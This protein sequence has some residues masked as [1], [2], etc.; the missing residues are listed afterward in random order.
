MDWQTA[1]AFLTATTILLL[2]PGPVMAILVGNTMGSGRVAGLRTVLGIGLGEV[3]LIGALALSVVFSSR[4]LAEVFPYLSLA[5]AAYLLYLAATTLF[6]KGAGATS[7]HKAI[8]RSRGP[9]LDGL[10]I[11]L[12]NPTALIFYTAFFMPFLGRSGAAAG[13]LWVLAGLYLVTSL[14]FDTLCVVFAAQL[15][16]S[17]LENAGLRRV[18]KLL[19][20]LVY[21][22]TSLLAIT[23]FMSAATV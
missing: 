2:T 11:T 9:F 20:A 15:R 1:A 18:T 3:L 4:L 21:L 22:G 19:S 6:A 7:G 13:E 14:A 8:M 12:S 10:A 16:P 23:G 5:G 17:R